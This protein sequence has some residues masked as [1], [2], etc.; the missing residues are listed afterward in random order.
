MRVAT[1]MIAEAVDV[2]AAT[3]VWAL[4]DG[5][6]VEAL[7]ELHVV[8]QRLAAVNLALARELDGRGLAV[9]QGASSTAVWL[10]ERMRMSIS[11]ARRLVELAA[12]LDAGPAVVRDGLAAGAVTVEQAQVI[13]QAVA[14]LPAE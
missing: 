12:A 13:I 7:D 2:C 11:A 9:A 3:A 1:A 10:R 8:Q 5:E 4:G 14:A 6:L